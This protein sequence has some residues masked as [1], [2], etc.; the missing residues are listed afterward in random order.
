MSLPDVT[1][2]YRLGLLGMDQRADPRALPLPRPVVIENAR[3]TKNARLTQR[4]GWGVVSSGMPA[5]GGTQ[6][7]GAILGAQGKLFGFTSGNGPIANGSP[8]I[9]QCTRA[10]TE[11]LDAPTSMNTT[12]S[13]KACTPDMC[14]TATDIVFAYPQGPASSAVITVRFVN[15][16]TRQATGYTITAG[17]TVANVRLLTV[18][19]DVLLGYMRTDGT[20]IV[21]VLSSFGFSVRATIAGGNTTTCAWDWATGGGT[22]YLGVAF[23]SSTTN[24]V[25]VRTFTSAYAVSSTVTYATGAAVTSVGVCFCNGTFV[26]CAGRTADI[27]RIGYTYALAV[28]WAS[29]VQATAPAGDVCEALT[30]VEVGVVSGLGANSAWV[31]AQWR[32]SAG[33]TTYTR[34]I[35]ASI[36]LDSGTFGVRFTRLGL[37]LVAKCAH[38][39]SVIVA[40]DDD[41]SP[42]GAA[43][44][45][46]AYYLMTSNGTIQSRWVYTRARAFPVASLK[47]ES[48]RPNIVADPDGGYSC[49]VPRSRDVPRDSTLVALA[50]SPVLLRFSFNQTRDMTFVDSCSENTLMASSLYSSGAGEA[51]LAATGYFMWPTFVSAVGSNAGGSVSASSQYSLVAVY[52]RFDK[53]GRLV[54]SAVSP[55]ISV[56][57]G[58][59]DNRIVAVVQNYRLPGE[60]TP[61]TTEKIVIFRTTAGGTIYYRDTSASALFSAN[62][63][64]INLTASDATLSSQAQVYTQGGVLDH[65][66]PSC[67]VGLASSGRRLLVVQ[68]DDPT[69]IYQSKPINSEEQVAFALE[70]YRDVT[71]G[72]EPLRALGY[73]DGRWFAFSAS[74]IYV[75]SGDGA[76]AT[77]AND[78]LSDFTVF[79]T[80]VGCDRQPYVLHTPFGILFRS[81]SRG[82][83]LIGRDGGLNYVGAGVEDYNAAEVISL[84]YDAKNSVVLALIPA[85][86]VTLVLTL[87]DGEGGTD[88]RWTV[89]T[90]QAF[91]SMT[92]T[93]GTLY[94]SNGTTIYKPTPNQVI[95]EQASSDVPIRFKTGWIPLGGGAQGRG[96]IRRINILGQLLAAV[97]TPYQTITVK[98]RFDYSDTIA[99]TVFALGDDC[100]LDNTDELQVEVDPNRQKA[101]AVQIEVE[102]RSESADDRVAFHELQLEV[103]QKPGPVRLPQRK[104]AA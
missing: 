4:D 7:A 101:Q 57:T 93:D 23:H 24:N 98:L 37:W 50:F 12:I 8:N 91:T 78:S 21:N 62:S 45:Q 73:L 81:P 92:I 14:E 38:Y 76:D 15:K 54:Q 9:S 83:W 13:T 90:Q 82:F 33:A 2:P 104:A 102:S 41:L 6:I 60:D 68:G 84:V 70:L 1:I 51:T 19:S 77:G 56:T 25:E 52:E 28:A 10:W 58:G 63:T 27:V 74:A 55:P 32:P 49:I 11:Q 44:T 16:V 75:A 64:T 89:D 88:Y 79:S 94:A 36:T 20:L 67:P 42:V 34:Y 61:N 71:S 59:A 35:Q 22:N 96:R 66:T 43:A 46:R 48:I 97:S 26:V 40:Y 100:T 47:E 29:I 53:I 65:Y 31:Y 72:S 99:Q 30:V 69:R 18:G 39:N 87:F 17:A 3:F 95:D 5:F 80:K 85:S 86:N 103:G